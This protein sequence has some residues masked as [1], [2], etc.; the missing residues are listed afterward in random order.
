M[1][2]IINKITKKRIK[3]LDIKCYTNLVGSGA[4]KTI[5]NS[6]YLKG[7]TLIVVHYYRASATG[8]IVFVKRG[9][10]TLSANQTFGSLNFYC[11]IYKLTSTVSSITIDNQSNYDAKYS[12]IYV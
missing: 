5:T 10:T 7:N 8:G 9:S 11:V 1:V 2:G 4:T 6:K 3:P 12:F